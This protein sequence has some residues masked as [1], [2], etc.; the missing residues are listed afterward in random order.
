MNFTMCRLTTSL[1]DMELYYEDSLT[2]QLIQ[3]LI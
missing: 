1:V 2:V 3:K